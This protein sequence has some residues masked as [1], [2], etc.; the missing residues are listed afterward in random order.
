MPKLQIVDDEGNIVVDIPTNALTK[1][2]LNIKRVLYNQLEYNALLQREVENEDTIYKDM[3]ER[4]CGLQAEGWER[5]EGYYSNCWAAYQDRYGS[6]YSCTCVKYQLTADK[7]SP[8]ILMLT[9]ENLNEL[10]K[11]EKIQAVEFSIFK[12]GNAKRSGIYTTKYTNGY[13]VLKD[14][15]RSKGLIVKMQG[16]PSYTFTIKV[17]KEYSGDIGIK[18]EKA[19][20]DNE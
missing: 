16:D 18:P 8:S 20:D 14:Y 19:V 13:A 11:T 4:D 10:L 15:S 3:I 9:L 17:G 6:S 2:I 7:I 12:I 1:D 5:P